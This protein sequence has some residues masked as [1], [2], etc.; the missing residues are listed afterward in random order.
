MDGNQ[1][2]TGRKAGSPAAKND[3]A[4]QVGSWAAIK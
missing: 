4:A 2:Q 3:K 1:T